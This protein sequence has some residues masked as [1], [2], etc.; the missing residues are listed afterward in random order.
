MLGSTRYYSTNFAGSNITS[1][2]PKRLLKTQ[3]FEKKSIFP[4][5]TLFRPTFCRIIE[6]E[7]PRGTIYKVAQAIVTV[8]VRVIRSFSLAPKRWTVTISQRNLFSTRK[9]YLANFFPA[10]PVTEYGRLQVTF[11]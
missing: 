10:L 2:T 6:Y 7:T 1:V 4:A 11:C 9:T 8:I 3:I 5:K